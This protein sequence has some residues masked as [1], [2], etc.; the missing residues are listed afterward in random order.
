MSHFKLLFAALLAIILFA[1][2]KPTEKGY[3]SAYDAALSKRQAALADIDVNL[4]AGELQEVDGM[5]LKEIDG[6]KVYL[7]SQRL[8]PTEEG[9]TLPGSYNVAVGSYKM[10]T[11]CRAQ[12]EALKKEKYDAF[13]ALG[14]DDM[15]FTI[16]GSFANLSEAVK[17]YEL[18]RQNPSRVYV[19][20]HNAPLI[21]FS[22]K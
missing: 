18:Y 8:K 12:A 20:L 13:P 4:P 15:Y 14:A 21:I 11:N 17:F 19:G 1:G 7:M 10:I 2:C 16:A 22:P 9:L 3:Q 5:Q 6:V